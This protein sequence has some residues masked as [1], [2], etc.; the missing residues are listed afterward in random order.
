MAY[1]KLS[2]LTTRGQTWN[3]KGDKIRLT[4]WGQLARFFSEDIIGNQTVIVVT[5][6]TVKEYIGFSLRSSSATRIYTNLHIRETWTLIDRQSSEETVPKMM[7]VD[8]STQRTREE[9]MFYNRKTLKDITEMRHG[10]LGSQEFVFTSK[11]TIDRVQENIQW[12][13]RLRLQISDHTTSTSCTIFDDVAQTMLETPVSSLLNLLDGKSD[14]IPNVIQQLC[15]KQLIFKFKLSE[16]NLTEGTPNYVVKRTFVPDYMLEKQY[17]INKTEEELMDDEVD[18]ILKQDR[19]TDQQ[20]Q[21]RS[22][23]LIKSKSISLLPVKE[24]LEDSDQEITSEDELTSSDKPPSCK[25]IRRRT[26]IIEDDSEEESNET[27]MI[28]CV[29]AKFRG[30]NAKGAHAKSTKAEIRND[31]YSHEINKSIV[32]ESIK[33]GKRQAKT[34]NGIG[35]ECSVEKRQKTCVQSDNK[36]CNRR[37]QRTRKMNSKYTNSA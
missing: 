16:Q 17:L 28:K 15:G 14:E 37:P 10:N 25:Q 19:E 35:K 20:E 30:K 32:E 2:E 21:T 13:Y 7:E 12:W 6:T 11:D 22:S 26:Y 4:L 33:A 24:E 8:K 5:S 36:A 3:I 1:K 9:Q 23:P 31:N 27:S 29:D 18:N 34:I